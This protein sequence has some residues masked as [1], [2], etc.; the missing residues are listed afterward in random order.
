MKKIS[1][2]LIV[3]ILMMMCCYQKVYAFDMSDFENSAVGF[4]CKLF[5][6]NN[7]SLNAYSFLDLTEVDSYDSLKKYIV[8]RGIKEKGKWGRTCYHETE[9]EFDG[10]FKQRGISI[11]LSTIKE[12]LK[13][14]TL[15]EKMK[16]K[17][18]SSM[19]GGGPG[20][21]DKFYKAFNLVIEFNEKENGEIQTDDKE[22]EEN[23]WETL[24]DRKKKFKIDGEYAIGWT[25][26]KTGSVDE[27]Y[28]FGSDG[29]MYSEQYTPSG[30]YMKKNGQWDRTKAKEDKKTGEDVPSST[31]TEAPQHYNDVQDE[32]E[33]NKKEE[34]EEE[35]KTISGV[36]IVGSGGSN[37]GTNEKLNPDDYKPGDLQSP[38][39]ITNIA[40]TIILILKAVGVI[41]AVI[42]LIFL[43]YK[44]MMGSVAQRAEYKKTLI[45]YIAGIIL[46]AN[47]GWIV[48][49]IAKFVTGL[50]I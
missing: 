44:Y 25:R 5:N 7:L 45:P 32:I 47:L 38:T 8:E 31:G 29:I 16:K 37:N 24:E 48:Q 34:E 36:I 35:K 49:L 21:Y 15:V 4:I 50:Q 46:L 13:D 10:T 43:G 18:D 2:I 23:G 14:E 41:V 9:S 22:D 42:A 27:Y 30:Y 19:T 28:Y 6:N 11:D 1:I 12:C 33:Q 40:K 17:L 26:I 39:T 3:I 20:T